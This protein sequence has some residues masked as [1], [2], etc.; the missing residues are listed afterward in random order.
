ML[1]ARDADFLRG[2]ITGA[3]DIGPGD[4]VG[5]LA[6][7]VRD[8]QALGLRVHSQFHALPSRLPQASAA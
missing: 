5:S 2:L 3:D 8:K 6:G 1:C 7:V 4:F